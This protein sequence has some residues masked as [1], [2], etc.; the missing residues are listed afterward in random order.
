[1]ADHSFSCVR[2]RNDL[3]REK[4]SHVHEVCI[5]S[6]AIDRAKV[7]RAPSA[8]RL[9]ILE[10]V[11]DEGRVCLKAL[12]KSLAHDLLLSIIRLV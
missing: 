8:N 7:R 2:L 3:Y 9:V 12:Q 6:Q 4:F 10:D 1:M 5:K 11:L